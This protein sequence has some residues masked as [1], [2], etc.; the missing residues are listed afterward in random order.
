MKIKFLAPLNQIFGSAKE[1]DFVHPV[2]VAE[3]LRFLQD[4][5]PA[6]TTYGGFGPGD[7]H[8]YGLLVWRQHHLMTLDE[9]LDPNDE[10]E[11][12]PMAGGG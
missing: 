5:A 3:L 1:L 9:M 6:F 2:S 8:P 11:M 10:L 7:K 12:V 4:Q